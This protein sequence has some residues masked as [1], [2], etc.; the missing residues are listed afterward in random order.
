ME[1]RS[2]MPMRLMV[3]AG[4]LV[5]TSGIA[6]TA[7]LSGPQGGIPAWGTGLV[8]SI[9]LLAV[10]FGLLLAVRAGTRT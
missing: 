1:V 10:A 5:V 7:L 2:D 8:L 4:A 6:I 3:R 9:V